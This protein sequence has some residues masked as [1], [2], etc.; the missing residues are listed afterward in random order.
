[1]ETQANLIESLLEKAEGYGKTTYQLAKLKVVETTTKVV[2][3]LVSRLSVIII[4]SQFVLVFS[5]GVALMLGDFLGKIYYGFF[6]VAA[7]YLVAGVVFHFFLRKWVKR[8]FSK[9][10]IKQMLQ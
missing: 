5:I 7:F 6:I 8:P 2:P 10:I 1:M 4:I 9:L 3:I